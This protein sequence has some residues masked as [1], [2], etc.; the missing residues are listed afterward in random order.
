MSHFRDGE[1]IF[2]VYEIDHITSFEL[3]FYD[4]DV[5]DHSFIEI[6]DAVKNQ[7]GIYLRFLFDLRFRN[8]FYDVIEHLIYIL[9]GFT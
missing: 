5:G 8:F 2:G 6:I 9:S 3:S 4:F 7:C 1:L